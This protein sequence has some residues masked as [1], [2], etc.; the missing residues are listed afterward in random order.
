MCSAP[1]DLFSMLELGGQQVKIKDN[2]F[3]FFFGEIKVVF[4][5]CLFLLQPSSAMVAMNQLS[6]Q[7]QQ[8]Q[9]QQL[10]RS[11]S[12]GGGTGTGGNQSSSIHSS[13]HSSAPNPKRM[14]EEAQMVR[15]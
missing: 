15:R 12:S 6:Q 9:Q 11:S 3:E 10:G 13:S 14:Y 8:Q 2:L 7:Q 1:L 4:L 5:T